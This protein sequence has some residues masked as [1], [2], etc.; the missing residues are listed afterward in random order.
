[1]MCVEGVPF[2]GLLLVGYVKARAKGIEDFQHLAYASR[3][4]TALKF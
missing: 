1:M 2:N 4:F 3:L